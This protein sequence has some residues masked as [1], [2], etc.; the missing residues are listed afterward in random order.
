MNAPTGSESEPVTATAA[1]TLSSSGA[2]RSYS[3][4]YQSRAT[5]TS[6]TNPSALA[7]QWHLLDMTSLS[8]KMLDARGITDIRKLGSGGFCVVWLV[9][10]K[11][12]GMLAS[13]RLKRDNVSTDEVRAFVAELMLVSTLSHPNIVRFVG[14]APNRPGEIQGLFEFAEGGDLRDYLTRTAASSPIPPPW[15]PEKLQI[16]KDVAAA[17]AYVHSFSPPLVHRDLK[18]RNVLLTAKNRAK[19]T[20]FGVARVQSSNNTMTV[21]V[22]TGRWLAPEVIY[23]NGDYDQFADMYSF[24]VLL[25]ELDTHAVPYADARNSD[26]R[27]LLEVAILHLVALGSLRPSFGAQ[28]PPE[29]VALASRCLAFDRRQRPTAKEVASSLEAIE[30][31][32]FSYMI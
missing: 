32:L 28:S 12:E 14:A 7:T 10:Y 21:G 6:I 11:K 9:S 30:S 31:R 22:G 8:L 16:A 19:L 3:S 1:S 25:S 4:Q 20:D 18:S 17:L 15:T 24:G 26:G 13:K 29:I 2:A 5:A 27:A 23:G